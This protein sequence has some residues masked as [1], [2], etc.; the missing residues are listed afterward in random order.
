MATNLR[1]CVVLGPQGTQSPGSNQD[2][3]NNR[4]W[5]LAT[6]TKYVRL[7][8]S[9]PR[10]QPVAGYAPGV[11][12]PGYNPS[13][14]FSELDAQVRQANADNVVVIAT[15]WKYPTW[16][17][18]RQRSQNASEQ[19]GKDPEYAFPD[20]LSVS[21]PWA[22]FLRYLLDRYNPGTGF[23]GAHIDQFEVTNEPNAQNWPQQTPQGVGGIS[24]CC[25]AQ[26]MATASTINAA[27]GK[28]ALML[29]PGTLDLSGTSRSKTDF[30]DFTTQVQAFLKAY[31]YVND[32]HFVWTHHNYGDI[33]YNI[34]PQRAAKAYELLIS[35]GWA[36][37]SDGTSRPMMHLTEGGFQRNFSGVTNPDVEQDNNISAAFYRMQNNTAGSGLGIS[38]MSQYL[39]ATDPNFDTGLRSA[40][41]TVAHPAYNTWAS[42]PGR[43]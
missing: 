4:S 42:F 13:Y 22:T 38:M 35:G 24:A 39:F 26:L 10:F 21:S 12:P 34:S 33:Q 1:K 15:L 32:D 5:I 14:L 41:G 40:D 29:G 37:A 27:Y 18:N 16:A 17:T 9:W 43:Y 23:S 25:T 6:N 11:D 31:G 8:I 19:L 30:G 36:G 3:R 7:W 20:D 2:Y 28:R